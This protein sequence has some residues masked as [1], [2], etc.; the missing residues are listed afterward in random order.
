MVAVYVCQ[1]KV[2]NLHEVSPEGD[3]VRKPDQ[4]IPRMIGSC[5][6]WEQFSIAS[7]DHCSDTPAVGDTEVVPIDGRQTKLAEL[8]EAIAPCS[9]RRI[10][11]AEGYI[12]DLRTREF[13]RGP[14]HEAVTK[15]LVVKGFNAVGVKI[16]I[17]VPLLNQPVV[18]SSTL[19]VQYHHG[20]TSV[21]QAKLADLEIPQPTRGPLLQE[22]LHDSSLILYSILSYSIILFYIVLLLLLLL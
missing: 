4:P 5:R 3:T 12:S 11:A 8:H 6:S 17:A 9:K 14:R 20:S 13:M 1:A 22:W 21:A 10:A 15:V 2:A 19:G 16:S 7:E 18:G